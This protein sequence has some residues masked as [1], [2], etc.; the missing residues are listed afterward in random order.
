MINSFSVGLVLA[1]SF[2]GAVGTLIVKKSANAFSWRELPRSKYLWGGLFLYGAS[3]L[4]Y[5]VALRREELSVLYPLVS[6]TFLW[7][8]LLSVKFL[9]ERMNRWKWL[10]LTGIVIGVALIG[11]GS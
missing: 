4:L 9:G 11:V 3:F 7:T 1:G 5:A 2:L 6:T 10:G 8:T